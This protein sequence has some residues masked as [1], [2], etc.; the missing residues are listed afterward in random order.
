MN[1]GMLDKKLT[2]ILLGLARVCIYGIFNLYSCRFLNS[3]VN[4]PLWIGYQDKASD[5]TWS[6]V[7]GSTTVY[8]N[9]DTSDKADQKQTDCVVLDSEEA[10]WRDVPCNEKHKFLCKRSGGEYID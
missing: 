3:L 8:T 10:K 1:R 5:G 4:A 9:W 6:W 7:D 2:K